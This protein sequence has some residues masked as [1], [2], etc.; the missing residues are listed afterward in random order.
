MIIFALFHVMLTGKLFFW[1]TFKEADERRVV[2]TRE[3]MTSFASIDMKV[4]PLILKCLEGMES[5]ASSIN[6][7]QA[8]S[9]KYV[10]FFQFLQEYNLFQ[11]W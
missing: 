11:P 5:A 2:K 8:S 7:E 9:Y 6:A 10:N 1:Q 4:Q 3:M